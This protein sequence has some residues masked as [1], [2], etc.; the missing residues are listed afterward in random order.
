MNKARTAGSGRVWHTRAHKCGMLIHSTQP[1]ITKQTKKT[2]DKRVNDA[3][4]N[5]KNDIVFGSILHHADRTNEEY[6]PQL[7]K[8]DTPEPDPLS[9]GHS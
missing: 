5:E 2:T 4:Q 8:F 1:V 3:K 6:Y 9:P 7:L